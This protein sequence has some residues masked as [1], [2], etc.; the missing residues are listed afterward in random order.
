[1]MIIGTKVVNCGSWFFFNSRPLL[2]TKEVLF[3]AQTSPSPKNQNFFVPFHVAFQN[4]FKKLEIP[5]SCYPEVGTLYIRRDC[6]TFRI[7]SVC[8]YSLL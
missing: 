2:K 3:P 7:V 6:N 4:V 8:T 1:M 5:L